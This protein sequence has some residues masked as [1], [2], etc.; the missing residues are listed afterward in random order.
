MTD[1]ESADTIPNAMVV[2]VGTII[3]AYDGPLIIYD[4]RPDPFSGIQYMDVG[5]LWVRENGIIPLGARVL[6]TAGAEPHWRY[7]T[8]LR[9]WVET[10]LLSI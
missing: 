7:A 9:Y 1:F 10:P 8:I 3:A 4:I 5:A 2:F 6:W